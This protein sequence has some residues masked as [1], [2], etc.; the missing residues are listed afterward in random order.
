[1]LSLLDVTQNC[2]NAG[3]WSVCDIG[4]VAARRGQAKA[5]AETLQP[6]L[7]A[8]DTE[9]SNP[10]NLSS[11][12]PS[13][14]NGLFTFGSVTRSRSRIRNVKGVCW[15]HNGHFRDSLSNRPCRVFGTSAGQ[16]FGQSI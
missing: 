16:R 10:V 14:A 15:L 12:C 6:R 8:R 2:R 1:V 11:V 9:V 13:I 7:G 4:R 5:P 3:E